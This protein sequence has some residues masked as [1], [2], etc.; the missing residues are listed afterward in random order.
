MKKQLFVFLLSI[1]LLFLGCS[2]KSTNIDTQATS[3]KPTHSIPERVLFGGLVVGMG[4]VILTTV[5]VVILLLVPK[6]QMDM[7][8]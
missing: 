1:N 4:A 8:R 5:A 2:S 7:K 6:A 3:Q